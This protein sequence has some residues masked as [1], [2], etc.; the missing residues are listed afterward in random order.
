MTIPI[1]N[2]NIGAPDY[3]QLAAPP[4]DWAGAVERGVRLGMMYQENA[5]ADQKLALEMQA[6]PHEMNLIASQAR[7]MS[8]EADMEQEKLRYMMSAESQSLR[9]AQTQR[10]VLTTE[11]L[12]LDVKREQNKLALMNQANAL[13]VDMEADA[14]AVEMARIVGNTDPESLRRFGELSQ[15]IQRKYP[16]SK[17]VEDSLLAKQYTDY[18][19][20]QNQVFVIDPTTGTA[21]LAEQGTPGAFPRSAI[22]EYLRQNPG[23]TLGNFVTDSVAWQQEQA[24][25]AH[26]MKEFPG[27]APEAAR[28][29]NQLRN[30]LNRKMAR[31]LARSDMQGAVLQ[32]LF[33][34]VGIFDP[35]TDPV[36]MDAFTRG[37][38]AAY[39][40][41]RTPMA[42]EAVP[43]EGIAD[44][45][46]VGSLMDTV[47]PD[48]TWGY[49]P[50]A[51]IFKM[52]TGAEKHMGSLLNQT[53]K[54]IRQNIGAVATPAD[55]IRI[56]HVASAME[57]IHRQH[58]MPRSGIVA[59]V[60]SILKH[61]VLSDKLPE[62]IR[63]AAYDLSAGIAHFRRIMQDAPIGR[64]GD[65]Q[66]IRAASEARNKLQGAL[67]KM[68]GEDFVRR[69]GNLPLFRQLEGTSRAFDATILN[70]YMN[71][72]QG[73]AA[74][75]GPG[76]ID[77][78]ALLAP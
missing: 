17:A 30:E 36:T 34:A 21:M 59:G 65:P 63:T 40:G 72:I 6:H 4:V 19:I 3:T 44:R 41:E 48:A 61:D 16:R 7:R 70:N 38:K 10:E 75:G 31:A 64:D 20:V 62:D 53:S 52:R 56:S 46:F 74:V 54:Y 1:Y 49:G 15:N 26:L 33:G 68:F 73:R 51:A 22:T 42:E 77:F 57:T 14:D 28:E 60:T 37:V 5:R 18:D 29:T 76:G 71:L 13:A 25:I 55:R 11:K 8:V 39:S 69:N 27:V 12:G 43:Y 32:Q 50:V 45:S 35:E 78:D 66:W 58:V 24:E 9:S 2:P 67:M 47:I 23:R